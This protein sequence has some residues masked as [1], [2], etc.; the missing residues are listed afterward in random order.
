MTRQRPAEPGGEL[1]RR[2]VGTGGLSTLDRLPMTTAAFMTFV[3]VS[4]GNPRSPRKSGFHL[5]KV[6]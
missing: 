4:M 3:R 2:R 5:L 6:S 1:R